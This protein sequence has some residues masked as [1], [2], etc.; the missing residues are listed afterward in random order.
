MGLCVWRSRSLTL[1]ASRSECLESFG[2][3]ACIVLFVYFRLKGESPQGE[4]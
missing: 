3:V 1:R 2:L 4:V